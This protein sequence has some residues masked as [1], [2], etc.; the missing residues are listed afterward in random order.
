MV[1]PMME[2]RSTIP[3]GR[4]APTPPP[5]PYALRCASWAHPRARRCVAPAVPESRAP[6]PQRSRQAPG[7]AGDLPARPPTARLRARLE[8]H[9][10]PPSRDRRTAAAPSGWCSRPRAPGCCDRASDTRRSG[11]RTRRADGFRSISGGSSAAAV[12]PRRP[13]APPAS[14]APPRARTRQRSSSVSAMTARFAASPALVN[15]TRR[16]AD[17][18]L[19]SVNCARVLSSP[20]AAARWPADQDEGDREPCDARRRRAREIHSGQSSTPGTSSRARHKKSVST[21]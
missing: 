13:S 14:P 1:A 3:E 11:R 5:W 2:G 10:L 8:R 16:S 9:R 7:R 17:R 12:A 6:R 18:L 20:A 4:S 19:A 15:W 21:A